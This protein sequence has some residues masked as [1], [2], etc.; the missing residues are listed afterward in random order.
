MRSSRLLAI[1][2]HLEA[3]RT[4]TTAELAT[5]TEVSQRTAHRDVAALQA[6]G[7]P[8]W[9]EV[10]PNGGVRL[11]DGWQSGIDRMNASEAGILLS[12]IHI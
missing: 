7:V 8:L 6:A 12:L 11:L 4:T 2:I 1:L 3:V 9:T 10:G 5:L